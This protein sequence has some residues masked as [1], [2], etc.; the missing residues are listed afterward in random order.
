[1]CGGGACRCAGDSLGGRLSP[2]SHHTVPS[3]SPRTR[4]DGDSLGGSP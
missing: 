2:D 4:G 1:M 3:A